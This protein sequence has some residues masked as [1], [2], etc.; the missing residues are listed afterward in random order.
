[1]NPT[2]IDTGKELERLEGVIRKNLAA[3]YEVGRAL[4]EIEK[5]GISGYEKEIE[6]WKQLKPSLL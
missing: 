6:L 5:H 1:M 2:V 3:F 4:E